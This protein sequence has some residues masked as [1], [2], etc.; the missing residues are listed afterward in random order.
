MRLIGLLVLFSAGAAA[1]LASDGIVA[2]VTRTVNIT[3]DQADFT[4]VAGATLDTTQ[5]QVTQIFTD[6]GFPSPAVV[7]VAVGQNSYT[8]PPPSDSQI[9][10]QIT[11][12]AAPSAIATLSGK[13]DAMRTNLPQGVTVIQFGATLDASPAAVSAARGAVLPQLLA[14][15]KSK[16]QS[17]A[18]VA[19]L[20][21]GAVQ[22]V[23][24]S[25]YAAYGLSSSSL[26]ASVAGSSASG[27]SGNSSGTVYTFYLN[28]KFAAQ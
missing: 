22:G 25:S 1:Q 9:F 5:Q 18:A 16:A 8:Y 19:S 20:T 3:P 12:T 11:F 14:E 23:S 13:L 6:A 21:L 17:L 27:S 4:V 24:E 2:S 7:G 15:A 28:V 10:Y 26:V